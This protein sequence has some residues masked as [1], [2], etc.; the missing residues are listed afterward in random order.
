[1]TRQRLALIVTLVVLLAGALWIGWRVA[2]W[3][4][5]T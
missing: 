4:H 1:M 3:P 2:T 5:V